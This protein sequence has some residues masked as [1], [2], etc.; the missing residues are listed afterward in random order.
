MRSGDLDLRKDENGLWYAES[1]KLIDAGNQQK[2][3]STKDLVSEWAMGGTP[4]TL[5]DAYTQFP[6][7]SP[8]TIRT[9]LKA[10]CD[11]SVLINPSRGHYKLNN[12]NPFV[13]VNPRGGWSNKQRG[14]P[15]SGLNWIRLVLIYSNLAHAVAWPRA[16]FSCEAQYRTA[17]RGEAVR[18]AMRTQPTSVAEWNTAERSIA[19]P[20][21]YP[22]RLPAKQQIAGALYEPSRSGAEGRRDPR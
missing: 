7:T 2:P 17:Q 12:L 8:E 21:E 14:D 15:R 22:R 9:I 16:R 3:K 4:F 19:S 6:Q 11:N 5:H 13:G 18:A 10:M 1:S 20:R